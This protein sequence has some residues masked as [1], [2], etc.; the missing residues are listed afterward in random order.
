MTF[1][2]FLTTEEMKHLLEMPEQEF[3]N[4]LEKLDQCEFECV[5]RSLYALSVQM[6]R[7]KEQDDQE[8]NS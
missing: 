3:R 1:K 2:Y 6:I 4:Y 7:R 8:E 5:S